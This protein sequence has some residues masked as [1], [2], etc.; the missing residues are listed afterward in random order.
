MWPASNNNAN[1]LRNNLMNYFIYN[2]ISGNYAQSKRDALL[3][4][5][6]SN[7]QNII[8]ETEN[9]DSEISLTEKAIKLGA[10]KIIAVGGDGTISKVASVIAG[11][12]IALGLIP[13]GSGNGLARHLEIPMNPSDALKKAVNGHTI[14]IDACTINNKMFFC[15]AGIGF[16]AYVAEIFDRRGKRGL[17]NY[18]VAVL[19]ALWKYQPIQV[20]LESGNIETLFLLTIANAN[21]YGNNAFIAPHANIQDGH[22]EIIKIKNNNLLM[23]MTISIRLFLKNIH[24]STGVQIQSANAGWFKYKIGQPIHLDGECMKTENEV[25]QLGILPDALTVIV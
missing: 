8:F 10:K 16:D 19:I 4:L 7:P 18:M 11:S 20:E 15:T 23:M 24:E 3:K 17:I 12:N 1:P 22:F 25:L 9:K 21:Q 13:L 14:K 2:P 6:R 5:I